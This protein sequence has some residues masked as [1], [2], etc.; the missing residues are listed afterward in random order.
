MRKQRLILALVLAAPVLFFV[1]G[2]LA[3]RWPESRWV[4]RLDDE[5]P[6]VR[7]A[8]I[9]ALPLRGNEGSIIWMLDDEDADV[10]LVAAM[11]LVRPYGEERSDRKEE[12]A[13][14]LVRALNDEHAGVRQQVICSLSLLRPESWPAIRDALEDN[15]PR[16]RLG[17]IRALFNVSHDKSLEPWP[18]PYRAE[19]ATAL[20]KGMN[21]PGPEVRKQMTEALTGFER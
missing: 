20:R 17:A 11:A 3:L 9:R 2:A 16:V 6:A 19:I 14:A 5:S 1:L 13:R 18:K 8:A 12:I 10:R 7:A 4:G 21:D 15:N